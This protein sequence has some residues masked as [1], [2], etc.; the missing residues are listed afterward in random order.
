MRVSRLN[1]YV[2]DDLAAEARAAGLNISSLTQ[3][4]LRGALAAKRVDEWLDG[5]RS[6]TPLSVILDPA[7][8]AVAAPKNALER[9][10]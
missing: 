2:S 1:V 6:M 5:V 9:H 7:A 8:S 10:C 3:D 4:A